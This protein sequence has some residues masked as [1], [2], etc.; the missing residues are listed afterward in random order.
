MASKKD[1]KI[2]IPVLLV[3]TAAIVLIKREEAKK[4]SLLSLNQTYVIGIVVD[5]RYP[6]K[7]DPII[8]YSYQFYGRNYKQSSN[9]FRINVGERYFISIPEGHEDQGIILLDKPVA[10]DITATPGGGWEELPV[11]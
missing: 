3:T 5:K 4:D 10:G 1:L 2:W 11:E 9:G 7:G 8:D 6:T